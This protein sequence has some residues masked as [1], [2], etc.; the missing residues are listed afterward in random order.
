M[1]RLIVT[2]LDDTLLDERG[3]LPR[4]NIDALKQAQQR[5]A[6]VTIATGRMTSAAVGFARQLDIVSPM[7]VFNGGLVYDPLKD[8]VI[9]E[10]PIDLALTRE[11][12]RMAENMGVYAQYFDR[13]SYYFE[14]VCS[15]ANAYGAHV[16]F[17]GKATG[18]KLSEWITAPAA[19]LLM[20]TRPEQRDAI[21]AEFRQAFSD[22]LHVM[23]T[24]SSYI[25]FVANGVDKGVALQSLAEALGVARDEVAAFGDAQNDIGMLQWAGHGYCMQNGRDEVKAAAKYIAPANR[26]C[27][28]A[29]AIEKMIESG[30]L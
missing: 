8:H 26:D 20:D 17:A 24:R 13:E 5:G 15:Y 22:R 4:R 29:C 12:L 11:I 23:P 16:G 27:G 1:I 10:K 2:D 6:I 14:R 19:K 28:V 21:C 18:C 3:R 9:Y 30:L 25:E 7:I